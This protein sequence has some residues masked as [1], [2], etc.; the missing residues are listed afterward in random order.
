MPLTVVMAFVTIGIW[1]R[2]SERSGSSAQ[3][4]S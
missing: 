4:P 2:K 3:R 1:V